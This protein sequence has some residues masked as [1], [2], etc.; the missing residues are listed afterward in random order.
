[1]A[2]PM[3]ACLEITIFSVRRLNL[4]PGAHTKRREGRCGAK[5]TNQRGVQLK[6]RRRVM[7]GIESQTS[8][9]KGGGITATTEFF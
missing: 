2:C 9:F 3:T 5:P 7:S 6:A 4:L 8:A 1:M